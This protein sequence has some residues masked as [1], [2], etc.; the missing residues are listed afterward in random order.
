[1]THPIS[2]PICQLD[3]FGLIMPDEQHSTEYSSPLTGLV[4]FTCLS[5]HTFFLR[6]QE[7]QG[8]DSVS[9]R[10]TA[11]QACSSALASLDDDVVR[12]RESLGKLRAAKDFNIE[13]II[14]QFKTAILSAQKVRGW[15][16]SEL[17]AASWKTRE[18]LDGFLKEIQ[19]RL[20]TGTVAQL[21]VR[22][23]AL[24]TELERGSIVH[25]RAGRMNQ[26]NQLREEAIKE[27]RSLAGSEGAPH[28]LPG[29]EANQWI[30]WACGLSEPEDSVFLGALGSGFPHLDDF[31]A[32]LEPGAWRGV[33]SP[34]SE[35]LPESKTTADKVCQEQPRLETSGSQQIP[36]PSEPIPIKSK[37]AAEGRDISR[38]PQSFPDPRVSVSGGDKRAIKF[39]IYR[40]PENAV[41]VDPKAVDHEMFAHFGEQPNGMG[42]YFHWDEVIASRIA[43]GEELDTIRAYFV[44]RF[45]ESAMAAGKKEKECHRNY[46]RLIEITDWLD[47]NFT[48]EA[49]GA[50]VSSL[51]NTCAP[52]TYTQ[53]HSAEIVPIRT[54][55]DATHRPVVTA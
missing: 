55:Q 16:Q 7:A 25:R 49:A 42:Y 6:S 50:S 51:V 2:C 52:P 33:G 45:D 46:Q 29:P 35:I 1:M 41:A 54:R 26:L 36:V 20:A 22:L 5:G 37:A 23:L 11:G 18:E 10:Q 40:K 28:T 14:K 24:A 15:V 17:P 38:A 9:A 31:V 4:E 34:V 12:L 21:R 48:L 53:K 44:K 13:E 30:E 47:Q 3:A 19:K 39:R 43:K 27:L 32:N 8:Q